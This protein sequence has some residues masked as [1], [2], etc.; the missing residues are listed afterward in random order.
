MDFTPYLDM[1]IRHNA[2]DIF[3][4]AGSPVRIKIEGRLRDVGEAVYSPEMCRD[5]VASLM[6]ASQT[7]VFER[8]RE[9]DFAVGLAEKGRFRVNAFYQCGTPA[10]VIR[11]LSNRIPTCAELGLPPVLETL[12]MQRRGIVLMV[13]ATGSGKSTTLAAMIDYRNR[14]STGHILTIEDPV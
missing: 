2:S 11:Y 4:T 12:A 3:V 6:N 9:L 7:E 5:A 1:M 8:E 10:M 13:G 14:N